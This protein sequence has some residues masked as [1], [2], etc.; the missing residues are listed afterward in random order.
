MFKSLD[1]FKSLSLQMKC[2]LLLSICTLQVPV[3][4]VKG[5][6]TVFPAPRRLRA[7]P[8]LKNTE[9]GVQGCSGKFGFGGA[10]V[11]YLGDDDGGTDGPERGADARSAG[12]PRGVRSGGKIFKKSAW[13]SHIFGPHKLDTMADPAMGGLGAAAPH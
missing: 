1:A 12:A 7:R 6:G 13:K 10:L 2:F 3:K 11:K 5:G 9:Q 8:S 4:P